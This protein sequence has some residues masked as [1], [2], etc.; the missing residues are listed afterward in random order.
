M[1][2][3][4]YRYGEY[5]HRAAETVPLILSRNVVWVMRP[6]LEKIDRKKALVAVGDAL[7][8]LAF[9]SVGSYH[10]GN[11]DPLHFV[12]AALPFVLGWFLVAPLAGAHGEFPSLRNEATSLLGTWLVAALVG[13][14]LRST[15]VFVGDSPPTFGFVVVVVGGASLVVWR[16]GL[17][18]LFTFLATR[19]ADRLDLSADSFLRGA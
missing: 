9:V 1:P 3:E 14:G 10:H 5:E 19:V 13:L 8:V 12:S 6:Y 11:T 18:R 16:L 7:T 17:V 2:T 15:E 4:G